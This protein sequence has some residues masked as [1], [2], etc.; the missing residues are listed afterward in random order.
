MTRGRSV[1]SG[2][3]LAVLVAVITTALGAQPV[4]AAVLG[5]VV[6][7]LLVTLAHARRQVVTWPPPVVPER[8]AGWYPASLLEAAISQSASDPTS[9]DSRLRPRLRRLAEG[10]LQRLGVGWDDANAREVLGGGVHDLL[11]DGFT[12]AGPRAVRQVMD[13]VEALDVRIAEVKGSVDTPRLTP[14][15]EAHG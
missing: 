3:G 10:R 8:G 9:F 12:P 15:M 5:I 2:V 1:A 13:S 6:G 11:S 14:N 7:G 4:R